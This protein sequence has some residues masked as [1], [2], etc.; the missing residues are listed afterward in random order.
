MG[1]LS[2]RLR[3]VAGQPVPPPPRVTGTG[4]M[5][6]RGPNSPPPIPPPTRAELESRASERDLEYQL[7]LGRRDAE[8]LA[9]VERAAAARSA[10][11]VRGRGGPAMAT[12]LALAAL[13]TLAG[14]EPP[15]G[16]R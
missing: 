2:R 6:T 9:E 10:G 16:R 1:S 12:L 11:H 8:R 13:G 7:A 15:R 4:M 3:K 5:I 14:A